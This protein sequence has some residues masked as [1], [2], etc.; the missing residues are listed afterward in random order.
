M[1]ESRSN[2]AG[3]LSSDS[4][5]GVWC[6]HK[7]VIMLADLIDHARPGEEIEVLPHIMASPKTC[8]MCLVG[9]CR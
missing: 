5:H 4:A 8:L 9:V 2:C 6:R 7:E 1:D 3:V